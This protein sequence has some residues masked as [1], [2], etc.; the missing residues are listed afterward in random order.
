MDSSAAVCVGGGGGGVA[1]KAIETDRERQVSQGQ[2]ALLSF[3][4]W[5]AERGTIREFSVSENG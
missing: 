3:S 5:K 1:E 4:P 2:K